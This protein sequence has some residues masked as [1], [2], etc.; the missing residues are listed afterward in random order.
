MRGSRGA[1]NTDANRRLAMLW[2]DENDLIR[3]PVGSTYPTA[4]QIKTTVAEQMEDEGSLYRYYCRLLSIRHRYAAIARGQ[5]TS[6][7]CG[8]KNLGGFLVTHGEEKLVILHNNSL[9]AITYDLSSC[10]GLTGIDVTKLCE[11]IGVGTATLSGTTLT[12][13]AQTSVILK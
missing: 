11:S 6:L 4:N 2:G 1:A 7:S 12:I 8:Q 5:Y 13:G 9:E 3:D 10:A